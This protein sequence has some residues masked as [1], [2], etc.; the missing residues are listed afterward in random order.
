MCGNFG[1]ILLRQAQFQVENQIKSSSF[2]LDDSV[3]ESMQRVASTHGLRVASTHGQESNEL[4]SICNSSVPALLDVIDILE[5]Q[6]ANTEL[7]GGQA[8]GFSSIQYP[9]DDSKPLHKRVRCVAR[10][11]YPLS[12][13]L[14]S[15][16]KKEVKSST[17][18]S[19]DIV[20]VIGHTRFATSSINIV[21]EL[22]PHQAII[23]IY[24]KLILSFFPLLVVSTYG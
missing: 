15:M 11:R 6:T 7:R 12:R 14:A 21:E 8:G 18:Q 22:H 16:Y 13:D 24:L 5:S 3:H 2:H 17:Q 19:N 1:L 9:M 20:S 10:K 4:E 23:I